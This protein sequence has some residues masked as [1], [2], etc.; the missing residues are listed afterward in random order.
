M[1]QRR[2]KYNA[3]KTKIDDYTFDSKAEARRYRAL[4]LMQ[5]SGAILHLAVHPKYML[6][7][8]FLDNAGA[9]IRAIT[10][11]GDFEYV[12]EPD[13]RMVVE[14]V[15]GVET[16]VFKI[17]AKMFKRI[18]PEYDFRIIPAKDVK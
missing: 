2:G 8:P 9:K 13:A 3:R 4:K 11:T 10:Y 12:E 15:K 17:K 1:T 14:D 6:Q 18:Y 7:M 16:A 5:R